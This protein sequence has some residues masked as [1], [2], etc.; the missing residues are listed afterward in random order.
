MSSV[1]PLIVERAPDWI[2]DLIPKRRLP[3]LSSPY[4]DG[5]FITAKSE[6]E[7]SDEMYHTL[8]YDD[9]VGQS[10]ID[11][12]INT[13]IQAAPS[14]E[15][16]PLQRLAEKWLP[17][18]L[19]RLFH[20][21]SHEPY[22]PYNN[23]SRIGWPFNT[24]VNDK[25]FVVN[26]GVTGFLN[27]DMPYLPGYCTKGGRRQIEPL[28][29]KRSYFVIDGETMDVTTFELDRSKYKLPFF[30]SGLERH[31]VRRRDVFSFPWY[32]LMT[33]VADTQLHSVFTNYKPWHHDMAR[34]DA[35]GHWA[36]LTFD[37]A[38]YE[39]AIWVV[40]D[41]MSQMLGGVYGK[42]KRSF[43][44][45]TPF[46]C[47]AFKGNKAFLVR[48]NLT[49]GFIPQLG[50]GV[51]D[52]SLVGKLG[53]AI[54]YLEYIELTTYRKDEAA[55]ALLFDGGPAHCEIDN[56]GDDNLLYNRNGDRGPLEECAE[57]MKKYFPV[58]V[59]DKEVFCGRV[60]SAE[61]ERWELDP[62]S[63]VKHTW[64]RERSPRPP[65]TKFPWY[66]WMKRRE[67]Y[68]TQGPPGMDQLFDKEDQLIMAAGG[69]PSDIY[70]LGAYEEK[71]INTLFPNAAALLADEDIGFVMFSE[72]DDY[73]LSPKTKVQMGDYLGISGL[74]PSRCKE[75][76]KGSFNNEWNKQVP[77]NQ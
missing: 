75:I 9:Y 34:K 76:I 30:N 39:R 23:V 37:V 38:H 28:G 16:A 56:Q 15:F 57:F 13:A 42:V 24:F 33:Q 50:S 36:Y 41:L 51:S 55:I 69:V 29:K 32:N 59:E 19:R 47:R 35:P 40:G 10:S 58:T 54:A 52:V 17:L 67:I 61:R 5:G 74:L 46:L 53:M 1:S 43:Y 70:K 66:A 18:V 68:T 6:C 21:L 63:Y 49:A 64:T 26:Q 12:P 44:R 73:L 31:P 72:K 4:A 45:E 60:R 14:S 22:Q 65:F 77:W 27:D 2:A 71:R 48:P 8:G 3:N 7:I 11:P 62:L 25:A 20:E